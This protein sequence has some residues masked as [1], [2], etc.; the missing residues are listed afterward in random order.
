MCAL[1]YIIQQYKFSLPLQYM[2]STRKR[3][4]ERERERGERER[5]KDI[6]LTS[7]RVTSGGVA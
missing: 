1:H 4:G 2:Q 3:E 5:E 6:I 7:T